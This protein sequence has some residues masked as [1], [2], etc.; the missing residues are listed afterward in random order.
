MK[1]VMGKSLY[2]HLSGL[3]E[4]PQEDIKLRAEEC[5]KALAEHPDYPPEVTVEFNKFQKDLEEISLDDLQGIYSYTFEL[6]SEFTV[7]LGS[8]LYDGFKR[9][10][11]LASI[12][13][14]YREQGFPFDEVAKGE[15]PD[16]LP[17]V[18]RFLAFLQDEGLKRNFI[19][20]F[21][22]I[23]LEKV[24]KSFEKNKKNIYR[25]LISVIYRIID[26]DVKEVK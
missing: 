5:A 16:H 4:Y 17:V 18:L 26:K 12:K 11:I 20:T 2:E 25:H 24:N 10:N 19:E 8:H 22:I 21:V 1:K 6:S 13:A 3:L 15:L 7:D 23:A 14:M 9:S